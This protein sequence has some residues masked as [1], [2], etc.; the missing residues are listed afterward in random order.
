MGFVFLHNGILTLLC[1][2]L[3]VPQEMAFNSIPRPKVSIESGISSFTDLKSQVLILES[4]KGALPWAKGTQAHSSHLRK[5][6]LSA[7]NYNPPG[8]TSPCLNIFLTT[9]QHLLLSHLSSALSLTW[10]HFLWNSF[11]S[12]RTKHTPSLNKFPLHGD[13]QKPVVRWPSHST[14][15]AEG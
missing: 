5:S 8:T 6:S 12:C 1:K 2:V 14:G 7:L 10:R 15:D 13:T 9:P 3:T 11:C 4:G